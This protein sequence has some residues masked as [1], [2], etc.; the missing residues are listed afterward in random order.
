M[1]SKSALPTKR[2]RTSAGSANSP[3]SPRDASEELTQVTNLIEKRRLQNRISQQNYRNKIRVRLEK[4]EALVDAS[5]LDEKKTVDKSRRRLP[6]NTAARDSDHMNRS[7]LPPDNVKHEVANQ[8]FDVPND[9]SGYWRPIPDFGNPRDGNLENFSHGMQMDGLTSSLA[10]HSMQASC[11]ASTL[12][13][14]VGADCTSV[15]S[16][17]FG[18][19]QA[20]GLNYGLAS[21]GLASGPTP[22]TPEV[23]GV[24]PKFSS[25]EMYHGSSSESRLDSSLY[26]QHGYGDTLSLNPMAQLNGAFL[27]IGPMAYQSSSAEACGINSTSYSPWCISS[28]GHSSTPHNPEQQYI[29]IPFPVSVANMSSEAVK[30]RNNIDSSS[31]WKQ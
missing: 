1:S 12:P 23:E 26:G 19:S 20:E 2:A 7:P 3:K 21:S 28:F 27:P 8:Q 18:A 14:P 22:G 17:T 11:S 6:P 5:G 13:D 31:G 24:D 15:S 25:M 30:P 10:G 4:L 16:S 29:W 9:C